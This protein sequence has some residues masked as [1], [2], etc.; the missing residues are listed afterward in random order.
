[1]KKRTAWVLAAGV[2]ALAL[3]AAAVGAVALVLRGGSR[4]SLGW[5]AGRSTSRSIWRASCPSSRR[6]A[7]RGCSRPG[8]RRSDGGRGDRQRGDRPEGA[9]PAAAGGATRGRLGAHRR[10]AGRARAL[11][12]QRQAVLGAPR[13]RRQPRVLPG[14]RL[15]EDRRVADRHARRLGPGR[16]GHLLQGHARQDRGRGPVRGRRQVQERAEPVHGDG[17][18][19][20]RTASRWRRSSA[21]CSSRTWRQSP[22]AAGW[23]RRRCARS[24]TQGP[25][26]ATQAKAAGLVDE[27]LYRDQVEGRVGA[28][29]G[30]GPGRYVRAARGFGPD[31]RP[32]I[33]LVYVVGTI[34]SGESQESPLG[35]ASRAPTP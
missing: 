24:S 28:T 14:D 7:S 1:M 35:G 33:A 26:D 13:G 23:R 9:R 18:S 11:P 12:E 32:Q 31:S 29:Q 6:R 5:S 34:V 10:G 3:G 25:F 21:A 27:L 17:A 8:R 4:P 22:R 2:A 20:S 30:I 16:R 19:P 15:P